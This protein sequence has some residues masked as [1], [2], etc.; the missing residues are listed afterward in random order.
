MQRSVFECDA[1]VGK[2][3]TNL[4][5]EISLTTCIKIPQSSV[6]PVALNF[7]TYRLQMNDNYWGISIFVGIPKT[8]NDLLLACAHSASRN[9]ATSRVTYIYI[10]SPLDLRVARLINP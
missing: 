1:M 2:C 3:G 5:V 10:R 7:N 9:T 8:E 6:N 4:T